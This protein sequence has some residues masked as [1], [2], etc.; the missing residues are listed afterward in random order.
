MKK[1]LLLGGTHY[2]INS[3]KACN[4][5]GHYSITCDYNPNNPGHKYANEYYEVS[6][7]DK[8][9]V[10]KLAKK[11]KI[12]GIVCYAADTAAVTAAYVAE[13]MGL[14][15][16]PLK[17]IEIL[18]N[19]DL[20]RKFLEDNGFKTPKAKGYDNIDEAIKDFDNFNK[21]VMVK[22]V[23]SAGSKGVSKVETKDALEDKIKYALTFSRNNRF[24]IEE[25]VEK[26]GYPIDG[27]GFSVNGKLVFRCFANQHFNANSVAV[28]GLSF[29]YKPIS[30]YTCDKVDKEIQK[31]LNLLNMR[32]GAYNIEVRINDN[33]EVILMELGPRNGGNL[34]AEV[35]KY[36]T[37]VDTAE[38]TIKASLGENCSDLKMVDTKGYW[39]YSII[40]SKNNGILKSVDISEKLKDNIVELD[41]LSNIG[42][43]V[44]SFD[45]SNGAIGTTILKFDSMDEMLYKMDN[46][47][48]Y[49]KVLVE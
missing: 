6:A 47:D 16:Q 15:G 40:H 10:L 1:V 39:A 3:I 20:F 27:D 49:I 37:G 11:L 17:S 12:D 30:K 41:I 33:D 2:Q 43:K 42:D 36:A 46:M 44:L 29:P 7:L 24:I 25:Y 38:W 32:T 19:K 35:I 14:S 18:T 48:R 23:D 4:R 34:I 22:P 28:R 31:L 13:K 21:P 26:N 5:L 8:E 9:A 45:N